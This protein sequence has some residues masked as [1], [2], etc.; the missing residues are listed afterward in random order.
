PVREVFNQSLPVGE[1]AV[2]TF[3][4]TASLEPFGR[5]RITA[6]TR[7]ED[8]FDPSNDSET[9]SV[10]NLNC[11]PEGSDC[12]FGDGISYFELGD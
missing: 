9:K 5:Y 2:F 10:A 11:I 6:R 12:S 1:E 3:N 4:Q 8:D 7:L